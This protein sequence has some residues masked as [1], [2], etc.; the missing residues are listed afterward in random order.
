MPSSRLKS[1]P[2]ERNQKG[3]IK[4]YIAKD[5]KKAKNVFSLDMLLLRQ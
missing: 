2:A 4:K 1:G 3:D 5:A